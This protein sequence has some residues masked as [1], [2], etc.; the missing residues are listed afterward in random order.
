MGI[1]WDSGNACER[2]AYLTD[3]A[4]CYE[5]FG[6]L[7]VRTVSEKLSGEGSRDEMLR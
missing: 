6:D 5:S 3:P 1:D 2:T 4:Y 7:L